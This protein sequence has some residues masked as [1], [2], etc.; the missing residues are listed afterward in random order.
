[1]KNNKQTSWEQIS[2]LK[3]HEI[4]Y[5]VGFPVEF[6][7]KIPAKSKLHQFEELILND[8]GRFLPETQTVSV[9]LFFIQSA[10]LV[11]NH[12]FLTVSRT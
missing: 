1:M 4:V 7:L 5:G 3:F 9:S 10:T 6:Y 11:W 12:L 8:F 2:C